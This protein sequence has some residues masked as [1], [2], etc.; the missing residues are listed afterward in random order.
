MGIAELT[1]LAAGRNSIA[2]F[3]IP[4]SEFTVNESTGSIY[5]A[6]PVGCFTT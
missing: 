3:A 1:T 6:T 5:V 4:F 2:Q